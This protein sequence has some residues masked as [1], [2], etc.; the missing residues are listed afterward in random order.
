MYLG[1]LT[2]SNYSK[3]EIG[4]RGIEHSRWTVRVTTGGNRNSAETLQNYD[5]MIKNY[6][7]SFKLHDFHGEE[8]PPGNYAFP[9]TFKLPEFLPGSTY[10]SANCY[11]RYDL[12]LRITNPKTGHNKIESRAL[13]IM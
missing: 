13:N 5:R 1:V 7:S 3:L 8:I 4:I 10:E 11:I 12:L 9:F 6:E 2:T